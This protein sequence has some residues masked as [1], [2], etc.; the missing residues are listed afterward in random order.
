MQFITVDRPAGRPWALVSIH[1]EPVN[2]FDTDLW[3]AL[4]D[5][6]KGLEA[7]QSVKGVV[8]SSGLTRDVFT[9]GN[10]LKELY[11]PN[12]SAERWVGF[13]SFLGGRVRGACLVN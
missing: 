3:A 13:M 1:K 5:C 7:D 6:L 2:S 8:L 9:A 4:Y 11:A 10:D 12:T